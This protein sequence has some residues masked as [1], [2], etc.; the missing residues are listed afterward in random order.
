[1][2]A[3]TSQHALHEAESGKIEKIAFQI[4]CWTILYILGPYCAGDKGSEN[5][6]I[7]DS[8]YHGRKA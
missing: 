8:L 7:A 2:Q 3:L 5:Q 6:H 1:M 4:A